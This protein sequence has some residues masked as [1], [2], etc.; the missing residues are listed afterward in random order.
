MPLRI[1]S[2]GREEGEC[3]PLGPEPGTHRPTW[4]IS[5]TCSSEITGR[6]NSYGWPW[7]LPKLRKMNLLWESKFV[8][9]KSTLIN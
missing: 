9:T 4:E 6:K 8:K 7:L 5:M 2:T 1:R 3:R